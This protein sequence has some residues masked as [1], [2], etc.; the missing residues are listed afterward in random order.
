MP[1]QQNRLLAVSS[2][3]GEDVLLLRSIHV[4]EELGRLFEFN[5]ELYSEKSDISLSD[6][7]G[8][9]LTVRLT[10][11]GQETRF[12]NGYCSEFTQTGAFGRYSAY[13]ATLRPWLWFLT[14]TSDCRIFQQ[15]TVPDIVK[16]VLR[17]H[18]FDNF[19]DSL[20]G[21]YRSW[22]NCVQYRETD[23]DF[24]SRLMEQE[25]IYYFFKHENGKHALVL[26]DSD[27]AHQPYSGY[28]K[29][30]FFPPGEN[31]IRERDYWHGWSM[32]QCIQP[33]AMAL[34]DFDFKKP[35]ASLSSAY[36][37][38]REHDGSE[39]EIY[40]YPGEYVEAKD[41]DQYARRRM[42]EYQ[43]QYQRFRA[44]GNVRGAAAG[45]QFSLEEHPRD[46]QNAEYL[47]TRV[48]LDAEVNASESGTGIDGGVEFD[49]AIE[50]I[51]SKQ[52]F[53]SVRMTP[54]PVVQGPQTAIV[55]GKKG[56]EIWTDEYGRVK[57]R[58]HWDRYSKGDENSSCWIR[59]AQVWA[60]K[61]WGAI[62][63]PRIGQEVIVEFLEGDPDRPIVT[64]RVYN[65]DAKVPY[66]LPD[67]KTISTLKSN[68][69]KGGEGFNEFRFEDKKDDEQIFL[70]AQKNL[71]VRVKND[72]FE[73]VDNDR[74][75]SVG[76]DK[77]EHIKNERHEKVDVHHYEEVG[78]DRHVQVAGLEAKAIGK[79]LSL[80]VSDDVIEVFEKNHSSTVTDDLY[81]KATNI[82]IEATTNITIKVGSSYVAIENGGVKISTP[83]DIVLDAKK[84]GSF[85]AMA[86]LKLE[87][88]ATTDVKGSMTTVEGSG[89][90]TIKGGLVKIN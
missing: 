40:D 23:F 48:I 77:R 52:A 27:S 81:V 19:E 90:C 2:P 50:C 43:A 11:E 14:R 63:T 47:I 35:K 18:G 22:E 31:V 83:G 36:S 33:G 88:P 61:K 75:L 28:A 51:E 49:C 12:F 34:N 71:D 64:G 10:L 65:G 59:V 24:V 30:A 44:Q 15:K 45:F 21:S 86:G 29:V 87:S 60:G 17:E 46:D 7:L 25:G 9:N 37:F 80:T 68:S 8:Q 66:D 79:S 5:L 57:V 82:V 55:V 1:T 78:G 39:F 32:T 58:F 16:E 42:E 84:N 13:R 20:N 70:H 72:R 89:I 26:C 41:G 53:R 38:P 62:Y 4:E 74:H 69:S 6:I 56:E 67:N 73:T 85:K 54:K 76:H 3:L